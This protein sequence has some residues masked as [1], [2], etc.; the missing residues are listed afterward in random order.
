MSKWLKMAKARAKL[1]LSNPHRY[2]CLEKLN[3]IDRCT[4]SIPLRHCCF[5]AS[6]LT[7]KSSSVKKNLLIVVLT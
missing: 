7:Q 4:F 2:Y 3:D 1:W 6:I 5:L